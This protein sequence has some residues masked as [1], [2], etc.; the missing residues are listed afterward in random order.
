[1]QTVPFDVVGHGAV[2]GADWLAVVAPAEVPPAK[3]A[4]GNVREN[5]YVNTLLY[6]MS[7][8]LSP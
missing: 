4:P 5:T 8:R 6:F 7:D 3:M 1:M 2:V